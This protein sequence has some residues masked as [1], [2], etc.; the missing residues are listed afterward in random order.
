MPGFSSESE[1]IC[2]LL[3]NLLPNPRGIMHLAKRINFE[4]YIKRNRSVLY[5]VTFGFYRDSAFPTENIQK[6]L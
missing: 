4:L 6:F 1:Y 3:M 2:V 5:G